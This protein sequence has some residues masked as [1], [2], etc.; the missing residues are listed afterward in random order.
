MF[1]KAYVGGKGDKLIFRCYLSVLGEMCALWS[2][3]CVAADITVMIIIRAHQ[4]IK[5]G[6]LDCVFPNRGWLDRSGE[7]IRVFK[8]VCSRGQAQQVESQ[9]VQD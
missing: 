7:R 1:N 8:V 3:L 4:N 9:V 6:W 2:A 5:R